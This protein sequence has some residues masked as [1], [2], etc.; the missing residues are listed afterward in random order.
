MPTSRAIRDG[1]RHA[2]AVLVGL[3]AAAFLAAAAPSAGAAEPS[4]PSALPTSPGSLVLISPQ[5]VTLSRKGRAQLGLTCSGQ[6]P[7]AGQ[8]SL[9]TATRVRLARRQA[10]VRLGSA[11]FSIAAG[12]SASVE[13][14]VARSKVR[15]TRAFRHLEV[16]ATVR[17]TDPSGRPRTGTLRLRLKSR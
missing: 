15:V 7:C 8:V 10:F 5:P 6:A 13:L 3:A 2:T 4:P 17:D 12:A 11:R 16:I 14:R 1:S 9:R